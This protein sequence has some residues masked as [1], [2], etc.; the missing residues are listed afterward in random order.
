MGATPCNLG[1]CEIIRGIKFLKTKSFEMKLEEQ[2][3]E[4]IN[5]KVTREIPRK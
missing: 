3:G 4:I 1:I 5:V 2:D